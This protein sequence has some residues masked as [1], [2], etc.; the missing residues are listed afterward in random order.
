MYSSDD[1][2]SNKILTSY[3]KKR[4]SILVAQMQ[5]GKTGTYIALAKK[6]QKKGLIDKVIVISC[7]NSVSLREQTRHRLSKEISD[8]RI[9][10]QSELMKLKGTEIDLRLV[11]L[12]RRCLL[13]I[14]ESHIGTSTYS[15]IDKFL[16]QSGISGNGYINPILYPNNDVYVLSVSATPYAEIASIKSS[17]QQYKDIIY[18]E[19]GKGYRGL[20]D[21]NIHHIKE[22]S[23]EQLYTILEKYKDTKTYGIIR[24]GKTFKDKRMNPYSYIFDTV[25]S[26][27][28]DNGVKYILCDQNNDKL[29]NILYKEPTQFTIVLI[30]EYCKAGQTIWKQYLS[31]VYEIYGSVDSQVQG[32]P[33]RCCGYDK[34]DRVIDIYCNKKMV[35]S[36]MKWM[37]NIDTD[38]YSVPN[39]YNVTPITKEP[40]SKSIYLNQNIMSI[41][42]Q[43]EVLPINN[44]VLESYRYL[45]D[46]K[47][48][49][50]FVT[51]EEF[52]DKTYVDQYKKLYDDTILG[53]KWLFMCSD[54]LLGIIDELIYDKNNE[55]D[56]IFTSQQE[57]VIYIVK[58]LCPTRS[59]RCTGSYI[60]QQEITKQLWKYKTPIT[61]C[62]SKFRYH[63]GVEKVSGINYYYHE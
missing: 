35:K 15:M 6:M 7:Y 60:E 40:K 10:F 4:W 57:L 44:D 8:V 54:S 34:V 1:I 39:G 46:H 29:D 55:I 37:K 19:A 58:Y 22:G 26:F 43:I 3:E 16:I 41:E 28:L 30:K 45:L 18:H 38:P 48:S 2:S 36:H 9:W 47:K 23:A 5:S 53:S 51:Q 59:S 61:A 63:Y 21:M 33:G 12:L 11:K 25:E 42:S 62:L 24:Q 27:C 20:T 49:I 31:F 32:L 50:L 13:I 52:D 14:D 56:I 17:V